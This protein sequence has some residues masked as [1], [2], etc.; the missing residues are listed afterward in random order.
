MAKS[1]TFNANGGSGT[2]TDQTIY[3]GDNIKP[4]SFTPPPGDHQCESYSFGGWRVRAVSPND[5]GIRILFY[6]DGESMIVNTDYFEG[7]STINLE[8]IWSGNNCNTM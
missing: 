8:A 6:S 4:N 2:M 3:N 7:G 1:I 5:G